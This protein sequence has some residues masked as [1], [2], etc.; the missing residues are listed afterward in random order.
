M[1]SAHAPGAPPYVDT[2]LEAVVVVGALAGYRDGDQA[3][4]PVPVLS[5]WGDPWWSPDSVM[6]REGEDVDQGTGREGVAPEVRS[7]AV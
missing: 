7:H 2:R 5:E 1:T 6:H 4:P 3:A